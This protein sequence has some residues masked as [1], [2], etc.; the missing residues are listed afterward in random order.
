M[1]AVQSNKLR[2]L[3]TLDGV[4]DTHN[5]TWKTLPAF[6]RAANELSGVI[7]QITDA[8]QIQISK[9]DVVGE[10]EAVLE[11]LGDAAHEIAATVFAFAEENEE[12]ALMGRM[13]YSRSDITKGREGKVVS[14]CRDI[15]AAATEN[16]DA[17]ADA[18]VTAA[19]LLALK[20][21]VDAFEG[22]QTQPRQN[23][24]KRSAATKKIP[25]LFQTADRIVSRRLNKLVVQFKASAPDFFNAYQAAVAIVNAGG[26]HGANG[27]GNGNGGTPTPKP[28]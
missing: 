6:V 5:D 8:A 24:S 12:P 22:L 4:L 14:R 20:K 15:H 13:D 10:K 26:G 27:N 19:K 3:Q 23:L 16:V 17:L 1:K 7:P 25:A 9:P 21:K 11:S 28:A 2:R 18:G